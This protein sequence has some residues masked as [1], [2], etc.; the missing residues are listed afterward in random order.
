M[1]GS[2][3]STDYDFPSGQLNEKKNWQKRLPEFLK[4]IKEDTMDKE[5]QIIAEKI[6]P[7]L[8]QHNGDL[9]LVEITD[10]FA[11]F[12]YRGMCNMPWSPTNPVRNGG[13][14]LRAECPEIKGV[15]PVYEVS[16]DL[17]R[18]ALHILRRD[19]YYA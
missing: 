5:Q 14:V 18:Q 2:S 6:R 9:E 4:V 19:H 17:I 15:I 3:S 8:Q 16:Q 7:I 10:G 13:T 12:A 11:K 1:A